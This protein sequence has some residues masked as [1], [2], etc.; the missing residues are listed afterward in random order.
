MLIVAVLLFTNEYL[1]WTSA[2]ISASPWEMAVFEET[3]TLAA[4]LL[5]VRVK[6]VRT[7]E[8]AE[9]VSFE[10]SRTLPVL[11]RAITL[12]NPHDV[13]AY[14][15][16][17][18]ALWLD[19]KKPQ[20]ALVLIKEGLRYNPESAALQLAAANYALY[21]KHD[22]TE[23]LDYYHEAARYS[24]DFP[25][26]EIALSGEKNCATD[27]REKKIAIEDNRY[28]LTLEKENVVGH[29]KV[30]LPA[31]GWTALYE[32]PHNRLSLK[33]V[34]IPETQGGGFILQESSSHQIT[35]TRYSA[36]GLPRF[37][38]PAGKF[39]SF[40]FPYYTGLFG[41]LDDPLVSKKTFRFKTGT[42]LVQTPGQWIV[43]ANLFYASG[44]KSS[45][46]NAF[47]LDSWKTVNL[48]LSNDLEKIV[49]TG[50]RTFLIRNGKV[51]TVKLP[52][53]EILKLQ[54]D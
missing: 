26:L 9:G 1:T 28:Q 30:T 21:V 53:E 42:Y 8:N 45:T 44:V 25:T 23:A 7:A 34:P 13:R 54:S 18:E 41:Y 48:S 47:S 5:W 49:A 6:V 33:L 2:S 29:L 20:E 4:E 51:T 17:I 27:P 39:C 32:S 52:G 3:R 38:Q 46:L 10:K 36:D 43:L 14:L 40:Y 35:L 24:N 19:R 15:L 11:L 31:D 12:A 50:N 22:L 16:T 37:F